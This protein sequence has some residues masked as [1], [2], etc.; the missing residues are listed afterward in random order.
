[1][2]NYNYKTGGTGRRES[3][4]IPSGSFCFGGTMIEMDESEYF[5]SAVSDKVLDLVA[6]ITGPEARDKLLYSAVDHVRPTFGY[7]AHAIQERPFALLSSGGRFSFAQT[8]E[9]EETPEEVPALS[10]SG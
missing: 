9:D 5:M 6:K 8:E 7:N 1:M 2:V 10:I 3:R 4:D